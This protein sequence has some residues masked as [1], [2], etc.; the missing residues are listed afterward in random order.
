M[1]KL[2]N[3][4]LDQMTSGIRAVTPDAVRKLAADRLATDHTR[5][6]VV[7]DWSKLKTELKALAW[8]PDRRSAIPR[9]SSSARRSE[10][11]FFL[12]NPSSSSRR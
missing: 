4:A 11:L 1:F 7:G 12:C 9:A 2:G 10:R 6:V 3:D 8:G 5:A